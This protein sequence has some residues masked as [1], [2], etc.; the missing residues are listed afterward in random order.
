M[1]IKLNYIYFGFVFITLLGLHLQHLFLI[2]SG[3]THTRLFFAV[4][5][6]AQVFLETLVLILL[7]GYLSYYCSKKIYQTFLFFPFLIYILHLVEFP[8]IRLMGVSLWL[9]IDFLIDESWD[10][11]I[12]MLSATNIP[13]TIWITIA[14]VIAFFGLLGLW[15]YKITEKWS[16]KKIVTFSLIPMTQLLCGGL[17]SLLAWDY[18]SVPYTPFSLREQFTRALPW[19]STLF[20][21]DFTLLPLPG[22]LKAFPAQE[23]LLTQLK[24]YEVTTKKN[25]DIFLFVIESLREDFLTKDIAPHL[26]RFKDQNPI[27]QLTFSNANASQMSWFSIFHSRY[28]FYWGEAQK[29]HWKSGALPLHILKKMG[30]DIRV[31]SSSQLAFYQMKE[32]LFGENVH[33]LHSFKECLPNK[34]TPIWQCDEKIFSWLNQDLLESNQ[35]KGRLHIIFLES[36]HFDYSWPKESMTRFTPIVNKIDF[37][38][39]ALLFPKIEPIKNRYRNA[40]HYIDSLFGTFI[41]NLKNSSKEDAIIVVTG[42]HGEEF[43]EE[44]HLFHASNINELQTRVPIYYNLQGLDNRITSHMDIFPTLIHYIDG[45]DRFCDFFEG[46]SLFKP[47]K[48]SFI[49]AARHNGSRSPSEFFIHDGTYKFRARFAQPKSIFT[50]NQLQI[51]SFE[52]QGLSQPL[53]PD[54]IQEALAPAINHLFIY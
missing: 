43:F 36:T 13:L 26:N 17:I 12:E 35:E 52:H 37:L 46:S 25:P 20:I 5:I 18:L 19:K 50:C 21:P 6:F 7:S 54:L 14:A 53:Q 11:F 22:H 40:I 42:D 31:Y 27:N 51:L 2:E 8:F 28:P 9:G 44:G 15:I 4:D 3:S 47:Q 41:K 29:H 39:T 16:H 48:N 34:T 45:E 24:S 10:N 32:F 23:E 38:Q 30:Y 33:L 49:I 1:K